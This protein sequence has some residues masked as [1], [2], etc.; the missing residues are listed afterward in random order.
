MGFCDENGGMTDV[1]VPDGGV[2][3]TV[4]KPRVIEIQLPTQG[5]KCTNT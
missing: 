3:S 2:D 5:I 1:G 4:K